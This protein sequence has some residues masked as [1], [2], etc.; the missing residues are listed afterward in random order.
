MREIV[1]LQAGQCGNQIGAKV[2]GKEAA[3]PPFTS[4]QLSSQFTLYLTNFLPLSYRFSV[5]GGY[6][7]RTRY[8]PNGHLP[9]R[10]WPPVRENQC[11][12]QRGHGWKVRTTSRVGWLG[13]GNY[14]LRAVWPVRTDIPP[15][16]FCVWW[17]F[18]TCSVR[19]RR[20]GAQCCS[21]TYAVLLQLYYN[22]VS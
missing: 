13:A 15:G 18:L 20:R 17:A 8:R 9:R 5:L 21:A 7:R 1:H 22:T 12:L 10:L 2:S 4:A 6:L 3:P 14:G 19:V 16:Q 11:L